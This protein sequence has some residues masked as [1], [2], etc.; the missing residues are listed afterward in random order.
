[1]PMSFRWAAG[2]IPESISSFGELN[3][4]AERMTSRLAVMVSTTPLR[5]ISTP[6]AR[7]FSMTILRAKPLTSVTLPRFSAGFR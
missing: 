4:E 1:M 2:P 3:E 7:P 5:S 6:T